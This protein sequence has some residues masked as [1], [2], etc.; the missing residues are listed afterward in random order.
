[1]NNIKEETA[2][3]TKRDKEK[4]FRS[5][6]LTIRFLASFMFNC[7]NYFPLSSSTLIRR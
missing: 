4:I 2:V 3:A 7:G 5:T 1:M 6:I